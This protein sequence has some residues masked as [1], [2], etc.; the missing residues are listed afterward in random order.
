MTMREATQRESFSRRRLDFTNVSSP[1]YGKSFYLDLRKPLLREK[2]IKCIRV[3]GGKIE[4]F[5]CKEIDLLITDRPVSVNETRE[6]TLKQDHYAN[7]SSPNC[8]PLPSPDTPCSSK[9]AGSSLFATGSAK[10]LTRTQTLLLKAQQSFS[11]NKTAK[12]DTTLSSNTSTIQNAISLGIEVL[13]AENFLGQYQQQR[14]RAKAEET[15]RFEEDPILSS[16]RSAR[17]TRSTS[18]IISPDLQKDNKPCLKV[19]DFSRRYKPLFKTFDRLPEISYELGLNS[20]T[21][22]SKKRQKTTPR[23]VSATPKDSRTCQKSVPRPSTVK[24]QK[25]SQRGGYCESCDYWYTGRVREHLAGS[26]HQQFAKNSENYASLDSVISKLPG[27]N[28]FLYSINQPWLTTAQTDNTLPDVEMRDLSRDDNNGA[29]AVR[30]PSQPMVG[31]VMEEGDT[32]TVPTADDKKYP[33][34]VETDD[35]PLTTGRPKVLRKLLAKCTI[36]ETDSGQTPESEEPFA[37]HQSN[38]RNSTVASKCHGDGQ[39]N[40]DSDI[41]S[42]LSAVNKNITNFEEDDTF[43]PTDSVPPLLK[44]FDHVTNVKLP[45]PMLASSSPPL[46]DPVLPSV[47]QPIS[48]NQPTKQRKQTTARKP[49]PRKRLDFGN[50]DNTDSNPR[51]PGENG[52]SK[53]SLPQPFVFGKDDPLRSPSELLMRFVN[54]SAVDDQDSED[55]FNATRKRRRS[56]DDTSSKNVYYA[57]KTSD[58]KLKLCRVSDSET[59]R[60]RKKDLKSY[61]KVRKAG[62]CKLVFSPKYFK[63]SSHPSRVRRRHGQWNQENE[64]PLASQEPSGKRAKVDGM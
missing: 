15:F 14:K 48:V 63:K 52:I 33:D 2:V 6:V 51:L 30:V 47:L 58:M 64:P 16:A 43:N 59:A 35:T 22:N 62:D 1:L 34:V 4:D 61:W 10:P 36:A 20:R 57:M 3:L 42:I 55:R 18:Q 13:S 32:D 23:T 53:P 5:L 49:S 45:E 44:R 39:D 54:A 12:R 37:E 26:R 60:E 29:S 56:R 25:P 41:L 28:S 46:L 17:V 40:I 27:L 50:I 19:E 7:P 21:S 31:S 8:T 24:S 9:T 38:V 11:Q